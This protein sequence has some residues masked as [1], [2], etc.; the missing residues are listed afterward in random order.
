MDGTYLQDLKI[1]RLLQALYTKEI[2][3]N[4]GIKCTLMNRGKCY[5]LGHF[6]HFNFLLKKLKLDLYSKDTI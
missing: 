6:S 4:S 2:K 3:K 5:T 1:P